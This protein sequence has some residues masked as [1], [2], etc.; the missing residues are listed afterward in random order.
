MGVNRL[1]VNLT[2]VSCGDRVLCEFVEVYGDSS[3]YFQKY[4]LKRGKARETRLEYDKIFTEKIFQFTQAYKH[5][6]QFIV[7]LCSNWKENVVDAVLY[8][9]TFSLTFTCVFQKCLK[10]FSSL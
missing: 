6:D 3:S 4:F 5:F 1:L 10:S 9:Y 8:T 7:L 2:T